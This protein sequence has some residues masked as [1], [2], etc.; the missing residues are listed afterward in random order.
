MKSSSLYQYKYYDYRYE[1]DY[2]FTGAG[3]AGLSLLVRMLKSGKF[4]DKTFL[5]VDKDRKDRND[6]TWCYWEKGE[7]L[8]DEVVYK[9][10]DKTWFHGPGFSKLYTIR[11]YRY[12]MIRGIDFYNHC[13]EYIKQQANVRILF[14]P[15]R[16]IE[17]KERYARLVLENGEDYF[18]KAFLFNSIL[19]EVPPKDEHT[20][21]FLQHF[22]GWFI[23]TEAPAFDPDAN[24]LMDFRVSQEHGATFVY[25]MP[26]DEHRAL[27]EYTLFTEELLDPAAYEEGLHNYVRDFMKLDK[28]TITEKE[29][30]V[31]P[32]TNHQFSPGEGRIVNIGT[33]G[34]QTKSSSGYTFQFIQKNSRAILQSLLTNGT[35]RIDP[36]HAGRFRFYD[37]VLLD[38]L[39][40]KELT[41]AQIFTR[42]FKRNPAQRI[43]RFL[44]NDSW[45]PEEL[46]LIGSLPTMPFLRAA[47]R[48]I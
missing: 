21:T 22:K 7:G 5:L 6:R 30:G 34:G 33:A 11:P 38:V 19:F 28:Y 43:F 17:N 9:S 42:L 8:F 40:H 20:Q 15:I 47:R 48:V 2:V 35:P 29:F 37:H 13:L 10:W 32:M 14:E 27:I 3:A 39:T 25:T 23:K 1:Y 16:Q 41:G 12:K 46:L 44:D 36:E 26:V 24:T 18:A 45:L 4:R 31:I